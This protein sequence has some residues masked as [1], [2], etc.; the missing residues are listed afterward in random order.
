MASL[1]GIKA[2]EQDTTFHAEPVIPAEMCRRKVA[3]C[4]VY[5]GIIGYRHGTVVADDPHERS[6]VELEYDEAHRPRQTAPALRLGA[7]QC[8]GRV[9]S[10]KTAG[11]LSSPSAAGSG[12][13]R[14]WSYSPFANAAELAHLAER[15]L[16]AELARYRAGRADPNTDAAPPVGLGASIP[17]HAPRPPE[18][19][20]ERPEV[21]GKLKASL[22]ER[23][24]VVGVT[25][26]VVGG[27]GFGKTTLAEM[28]CADPDVEAAFPGGTLW[29]T[30]GEEVDDAGIAARLGDLVVQLGYARPDVET[31]EAAAQ[32]LGAALGERHALLVVDDVWSKPDLAW[33]ADYGGANAVRLVT[34]RQHDILPRAAAKV[35]VDEMTASESE[36]LLTRDLDAAAASDV[37]QLTTRCGNWP[38]LL[39]AVNSWLTLEIDDGV[40]VHLACRHLL[41][42][43]DRTLGVG[44]IADPTDLDARN[45]IAGLVLDRSITTLGVEDRER[46]FDLAIFPEDARIPIDLLS[47]LWRLSLEDATDAC[48]RLR[49]R[50]LIQRLDLDND[51]GT[52]Q[53]HDVLRRHLLDRAD[54]APTLPE[55]HARLIAPHRPASGSWAD[56]PTPSQATGEHRHAYLWRN[57]TYHLHEAG[58]ADELTQTVRSAELARRG[59]RHLRPTDRR[60]RHRPRQRGRAAAPSTL[61][62]EQLDP[63]PA[64]DVPP[65]SPP[66]SAPGTRSSQQTSPAYAPSTRSPIR[67]PV[68]CSERWRATPT[69]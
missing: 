49:R 40:P 63:R 38:F 33:F 67:P 58:L 60:G 30:L 14:S 68:G 27:G 19:L 53:L 69:R 36:Q 4:D 8:D 9:L 16:Q 61:A 10:T 7:P 65:A 11:R 3:E 5:V 47:G 15:T 25:T 62:A 2:E 51:G 1:D 46:A 13:P 31:V 54:V 23:N 64:P 17:R 37:E 39:D 21:Y 20:V 41:N 56:L 55:R 42:G 45:D 48:R 34:T 52:A 29:V 26:A 28:L 43:F 59:L 32:A 35:T 6:F 44:T 66:P 24:A 22:L 50:S 57:L 18:G 12:R